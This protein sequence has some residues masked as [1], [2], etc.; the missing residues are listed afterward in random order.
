MTVLTLL[1]DGIRLPVRPGETIERAL[2]RAGFVRPRRGCRRGGC[3]QCAAHLVAGE[4]IDERP[5]AESVLPPERRAQGVI[6]ICRA[7]PTCDVEVMV[8]DNQVRCV[9][10]IQ[11]TLAERELAT[12]RYSTTPSHSTTTREPTMEG[13]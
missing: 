6:L 7:I 2:N 8:D 1:P 3:G 12:P 4:V 9:S 11:R 5:I 10:P 13:S